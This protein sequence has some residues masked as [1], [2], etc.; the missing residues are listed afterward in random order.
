MQ[1]AITNAKMEDAV[2]SAV[3]YADLF[4]YAPTLDELPVYLPFM[5][6]NAAERRTVVR[7]L[8]KQGRL[9]QQEPF[10][11]MPGRQKLVPL[12]QERIKNAER[13][14]EQIQRLLPPLLAVEG[15][16]SV[17]LT[18][19]LAAN[20]SPAEADADLFLIL[21]HKRM[22]LAYLFFRLWARR[23]KEIEFCPNYAISEKDLDL[24]YP[25][26]FTAIEWSMAIPVKYSSLLEDMERSNPWCRQFIPNA[27]SLKEKE[28]A[29][30]ERPT[31]F[32]RLLNLI[33]RSP[34]GW[35][36]NRLEYYR[37]QFRTRGRYT[38]RKSIYKPHSPARQ[39]NILK[40]WII[41]LD[42]Y[43]VEAFPVRAHFQE[44]GHTLEQALKKWE[45]TT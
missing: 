32:T 4:D 37:L 9:A 22:W 34:L 18:G 25:N 2:L 21:E 11:F 15:V 41:R 19:S 8:V 10:F 20:N 44:H 29:I 23:I 27:Y 26:V 1:Q 5:Q 14:W 16:K 24:L 12:R 43:D 40:Q 17:L 13:K 42:Q 35:C 6:M 38:P 30:V 45:S 36:L 28:R 31:P 3:C 33:I 7:K 39:Y